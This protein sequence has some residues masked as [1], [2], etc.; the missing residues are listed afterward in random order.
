[1]V[2]DDALVASG[3]ENELLD[4]RLAR[5]VDH[6]LE[7]RPI[8]DRQH[9]LGDGLGRGQEAGAETRDGKHGL[10]NGFAH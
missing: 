4:A 5:L 10:S 8:D 3:D 7:D 2:L 6:V 9:L 1:M